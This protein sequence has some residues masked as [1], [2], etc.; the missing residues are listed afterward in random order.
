VYV[1]DDKNVVHLRN[2]EPK[3]R[4]SNFYIVESGLSVKENVIYEGIQLLKDGDTV[5]AEL[6]PFSQVTK[7]IAEL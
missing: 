5:T 2:F 7:L 4:L 1:V 6:I 3:F